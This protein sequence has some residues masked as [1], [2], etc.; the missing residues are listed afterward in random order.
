MKTYCKNI[1][2]TDPT[3]IE[4]WVDICV[5]DPRKRH[6]QSFIRL[7]HRYGDAHNIAVEIA[8]RIKERNLRLPPIQH[9]KAKDKSSGK[10]RNLGIESAMQQCM[11]Y[12][13]VY[14]LMPMLR[15]KVGTYQCA[16][17]PNRG[18]IYGKRAL[19]KWIRRDVSGTKYYDKMDVKHC[20]ESVD[21]E[22]V[23]RLLERDIGKNPNLIWFVMEL[24][25]SYGNGLSIGSFLSQ[26]LCNYIMSYAYHYASENIYKERRGKRKNLVSHVL[27]FMDDIIIF[28]S[29]RR[30]LKM[31]SKKLTKYM[32]SELGLRI[33]PNH[34]V[35]TTDV[36]PPDMMGFVVGRKRTTIRARIFKRARRVL[37]RCWRK[38]A[39]GK[40]IDLKSAQRVISYA[41]YFRHTDSTKISEKLKLRTVNK[42][43]RQTVSNHA[44]GG[45]RC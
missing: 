11:D 9:K 35:K 41:G 20:Y 39:A 16:S 43:A 7:M 28:G 33:K 22:V 6:R 44:K 45:A 1:D 40:K 31:A 38:L 24:V 4:R 10:E 5:S 26:W 21:H 19:E 15:A 42:A 25:K 14:A 27:F 2:I 23:R 3:A 13:A 18:Q 30:D 36:E 29:S 8:K 17:V 37:L 32:E 12:V 34:H